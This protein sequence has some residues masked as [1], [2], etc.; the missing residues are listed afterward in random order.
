M[1]SKYLN[2]QIVNRVVN[3]RLLHCSWLKGNDFAGFTVG[4]SHQGLGHALTKEDNASTIQ[5]AA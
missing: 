2:N 5:N 1:L 3:F 4:S